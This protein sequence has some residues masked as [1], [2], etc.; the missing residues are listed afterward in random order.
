M[1]R[2]AWVAALAALS[3]TACS[4]KP[5]QDA[6]GAVQG[7][8]AAV[9][10]ND[11]AAFEADIDRAAL[12]RDLRSQIVEM[13]RAAGLEV[14]GGPSEFTLDRMIGPDNF[15]LVQAETGAPLATPPTLE[16]V[17]A[18]LQ[19]VDGAHVCLHG[20]PPQQACV[21]TF[22]NQKAAAKD[23]G[24]K[25]GQARQAGWRLVRMPATDLRIEV[26]AEPPAKK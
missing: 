13:G 14:D 7:F 3:L 12:R 9:L 26:G 1:Y 17:R 18:M 22:E 5:G 23:A 8:L 21:L 6:A 2:K 11:R 20:P 16:Q 15:H 10:T 4:G 19:P 24:G 25:D